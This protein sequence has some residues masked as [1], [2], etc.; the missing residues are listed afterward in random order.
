MFIPEIT[1]KDTIQRNLF[2][3]YKNIDSRAKLMGTLNKINK[4]LNNTHRVKVASALRSEPL[5]RN[6]FMSNSYT[7]NFNEII[8][9]K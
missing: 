3:S 2:I 4:K 7:T 9:V 8:V 5:M 1:Y 6:V